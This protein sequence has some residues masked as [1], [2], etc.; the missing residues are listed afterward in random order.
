[1]LSFFKVY[2]L[3]KINKLKLIKYFITGIVTTLFSCLSFPF[4]Y[5]WL[6]PNNSLFSTYF[7]AACLNIFFGF[8]LQKY[9]VFNSRSRTLLTL[10]K[11]IISNIVIFF[12]NY[13][14]LFFIINVLELSA[15]WANIIIV[16]ISAFLNLL[17][18]FFY[19]FKF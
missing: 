15:F 1:M 5:F 4:L 2:F 13:Y 12:I 10:L 11:F 9:F 7:I 17:F 8:T 16:I 18:S 3:L 19:S 6:L 14:L